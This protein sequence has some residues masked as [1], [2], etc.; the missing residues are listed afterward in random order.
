MT[1]KKW[2]TALVFVLG[3]AALVLVPLQAH[4]RIKGLQSEQQW[5]SPTATGS[6]NY[7]LDATAV[8]AGLFKGPF[9]MDVSQPSGLL[10]S[11]LNND[12]TFDKT[13]FFGADAIDWCSV[14]CTENDIS[15][16]ENV[17]A[18]LLVTPGTLPNGSSA[19]NVEVDYA[20]GY[21]FGFSVN[22]GPSL[23]PG[24]CSG[25]GSYAD[26]TYTYFYAHGSLEE[27]SSASAPE[28]GTGALF[29]AALGLLCMARVLGR[30][31]RANR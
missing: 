30:H 27:T 3:I 9:V 26:V 23:S 14:T 17:L 7:T 4:A 18:Q 12:N 28:A 5:G 20:C 29:M 25:K 31:R 16:P 6:G 2:P 13:S 21:S 22:G 8:E 11:W 10:G 1:S 24:S 19:L 15:T